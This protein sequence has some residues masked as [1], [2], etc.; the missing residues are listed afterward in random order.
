MQCDVHI[1][2]VDPRPSE[3]SRQALAYYLSASYRF[4]QY[5]AIGDVSKTRYS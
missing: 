4:V 1:V 5:A 3:I 2:S